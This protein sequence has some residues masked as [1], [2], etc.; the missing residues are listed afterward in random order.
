ML[1]AAA[2]S[3]QFPFSFWLPRAMEGPT[4]SSAIFY[5]SLSVHLG[6][7]LLLRAFPLI[8]NQMTVRILIAALGFF[9]FM[10]AVGT[11]RVQSSV[12]SQVAYS[13]ISHI[14]FIFIEI[15]LGFQILAIV[16]FIGNG[17]L[18]TYQLL[19][20]P[21]IVSYKIREQFYS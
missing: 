3:A 5:G 11:S 1:A 2:K 16:H 8:E 4:P 6:V 17:F 21:S 9:T 20:S 14:G 19:I 12:K 18:R 7:F 13:S 10:I 15:A